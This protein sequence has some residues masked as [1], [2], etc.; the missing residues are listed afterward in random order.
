MDTN[1][2]IYISKIKQMTL[3]EIEKS[4]LSLKHIGID[5]EQITISAKAYFTSYHRDH[6]SSCE[7][8]NGCF[9]KS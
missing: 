9:K 3:E 7:I 8:C 2:T 4:F 5:I 1:E 6:D